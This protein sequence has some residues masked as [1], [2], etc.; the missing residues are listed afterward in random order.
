MGSGTKMLTKDLTELKPC[1]HCG[2]EAGIFIG[3][4]FTVVAC[5]KC[6][7]LTKA[8]EYAKLGKEKAI[9]KVIEDWNRRVK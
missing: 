1:A 5:S 3:T 7:I 6:G 8:E 4:F 2:G 9:E